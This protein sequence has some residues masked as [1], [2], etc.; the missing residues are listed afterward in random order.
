MD[1]TSRVGTQY[2]AFLRGINVG[3]RT[4]KM[5]EL[6]A[7][8][9]DLGFKDVRTL[10]ASGNVIF[11]SPSPDAQYLKTMIGD[12]IKR[13]FGYQV[14]I[15]IRRL[16]AITQLVASDPFKD[17]PVTPATRLYVSFLS[18]PVI[19][20]IKLPYATDDE[21]LRILK[22]TDG[23]VLSVVTLTPATGTLDAMSILEG[24][25][26]KSI[27]MRSWNTVCKLLK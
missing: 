23:E 10:L 5:E 12:A 8:F 19:P 20:R 6:R 2:V 9:S 24:I 25:F 17:I 26:G 21:G 27:T 22:V 16:D 4:I 1:P 14:S 3:G 7:C 18:K 13:R 15:I 11:T